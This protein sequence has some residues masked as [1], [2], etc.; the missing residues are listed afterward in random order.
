MVAFC[1]REGDEIGIKTLLNRIPSN[2]YV[3]TFCYDGDINAVLK[4]FANTSFVIA[5]RFHS[6]ILG[7]LFG[8]PVF[9]IAYNCKTENYLY[10]LDFCGKY[11]KLNDM[12]N[13]K[14][15]DILFNYKNKIITECSDH[16][17]HAV[18]QFWGLRKYLDE[19]T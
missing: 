10:D 8:K 17:K 18:N 4:L 9:P 15:Q 19:N 2:N 14:L 3:S 11:V 13:L 5:S 6:F 12:A 16:K 1:V 7:I